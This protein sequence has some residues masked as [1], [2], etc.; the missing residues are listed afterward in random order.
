MNDDA[1]ER[2]PSLPSGRPGM[3][4]QS[5][6]LVG[7]NQMGKLM[8]EPAHHLE[9]PIHAQGPDDQV[10]H[11]DPASGSVDASNGDA[12]VRGHLGRQIS[13]LPSLPG[14]FTSKLAGDELA[15]SWL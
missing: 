10:R 15:M 9:V 11:P 3:S 1:S 6:R 13:Q 4:Q 2:V 8:A 12:D 14:W 5:R 7:W